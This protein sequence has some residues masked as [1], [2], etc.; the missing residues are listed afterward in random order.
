MKRVLRPKSHAVQFLVV[1]YLRFWGGDFA[2][3]CVGAST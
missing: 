3:P 2:L 1:K